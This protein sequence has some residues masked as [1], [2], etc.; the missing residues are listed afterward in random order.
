M[1]VSPPGGGATA[2]PLSRFTGPA[3]F[4]AGFSLLSC[5][6]S[7][8]P[9]ATGGDYTDLWQTDIL[10]ALEAG[11]EGLGVAQSEIAKRR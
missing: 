7:P 11:S 6:L 1:A 3:R 10:A 4:R 2:K 9:T 5:P 8:S